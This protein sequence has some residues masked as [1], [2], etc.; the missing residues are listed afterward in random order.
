M[1]IRKLLYLSILKKEIGFH[2][3]RDNGS[4]ILTSIMAHDT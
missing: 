4:S 3:D 2:D 1:K